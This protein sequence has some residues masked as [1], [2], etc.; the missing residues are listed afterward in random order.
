MLPITYL[1]KMKLYSKLFFEVKYLFLFLWIFASASLTFA[2]TNILFVGNSFTH[3]N[4]NPVQHYNHA[5]VTDPNGTGYGG[6]PA[7]F[8]KMTD[9]AGL[10][11]NVTIEAVDAKTLKWHSTKK[12]SVLSQAKWNIVVLQEQSRT[13][14]PVE[15]GGDP[16]EFATGVSACQSLVLSTNPTAKILLYETWAYA[17][18]AG[19]KGYAPGISGLEAMLADLHSSYAS[20]DSN[21]HFGII[22]VGDAFMEVLKEGLSDPNNAVV[23]GKFQLLSPSDNKHPS[24]YGAYLSSAVFFAKI[25][26]LDPRTLPVDANSA[27]GGL[28]ISSADAQ[29]LNKIAYQ[30]AQGSVAK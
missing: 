22:P 8:K 10:S 20:V 24:P 1:I 28:G 6:V 14:L 23:P 30:T 3:G 4:Y 15:H 13:P 5:S 26:G 21:Y 12:A 19:V 18:R 2:Q 29:N 16:S 17:P 7:I 27:A 11:Y 9:E 25:T